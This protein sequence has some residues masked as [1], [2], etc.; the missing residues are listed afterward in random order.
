MGSWNY[1]TV[2]KVCPNSGEVY[3]RIHE[4]YYNDK[5]KV[6]AISA[7]AQFPSGEN[8]DELQKDLTMMNVALD[9]PALVFDE[10]EFSL[11]SDGQ[12]LVKKYLELL[13]SHPYI[14]NLRN[15]YTEF[16][17]EGLKY[18][19]SVNDEAQVF[20]MNR[21]S[22]RVEIGPI[23]RMLGKELEAWLKEQLKYEQG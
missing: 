14:G 9:K 10:I 7:D 21:G 1:R 11:E 16:D 3:Y 22:V 13:S 23:A 4:V 2:E 6:T 12:R 18:R 5:G 17:F 19:I 20:V 15:N 8:E